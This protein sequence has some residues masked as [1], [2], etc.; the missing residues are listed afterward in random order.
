MPPTFISA[1]QWLISDNWLMVAEHD[2]RYVILKDGP[3]LRAVSTRHIRLIEITGASEKELSVVRG[4]E[5][6]L[7]CTDPAVSLQDGF[8]DTSCRSLLA[9]VQPSMES[10]LLA[11]LPKN[12]RLF[13]VVGKFEGTG[14]VKALDGKHEKARLTV[15]VAK[16]IRVPAAFQIVRHLPNGTRSFVAHSSKADKNSI[17]A[18]LA[19]ANGILRQ[20]AIAF[21]LDSFSSAD[22]AQDLRAVVDIRKVDSPSVVAIRA[23]R[24]G[25]GQTNVFLVA[26]VLNNSGTDGTTFEKQ[27]V[28]VDD[29][30]DG[31]TLAR[32]LA[33]EFG[34]VLN[35][36]HV[37]PDPKTM[38]QVRKDG[39]STI[40]RMEPTIN[41]MGPG[42]EE[43]LKQGQI[44]IAR[45]RARELAKAKKK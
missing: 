25:N 31:Y 42:E 12:A 28:I 9:A 18:A 39:N 43:A 4:M 6:D 20:A 44:T 26:K 13:A 40:W 38:K 21:D 32:T 29:H 8:S 17:I 16:V 15:E 24:V 11:T 7:V 35:L 1:N 5:R 36:G 30:K 27:D 19:L 22:V 2:F 41:L 34:H 37:Y 10:Y 33:H 23:K 45:S 3:G 14:L